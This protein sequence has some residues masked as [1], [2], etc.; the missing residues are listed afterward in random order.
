MSDLTDVQQWK[1]INEQV[2]HVY[3]GRWWDPYASKNYATHGIY[4]M[5][6]NSDSSIG[7]DEKRAILK[8][9]LSVPDNTIQTQLPLTDEDIKKMKNKADTLQQR[10]LYADFFRTYRPFDDPVRTEILRRAWPEPFENMKKTVEET[11]EFQKEFHMS[12]LGG[13]DKKNIM[14][15]L[16]Y[17]KDKDLQDA[18]GMSFGPTTGT[19]TGNPLIPDTVGWSD[20]RHVLFER[21]FLN[22]RRN[23]YMKKVSTFYKKVK[24]DGIISDARNVSGRTLQNDNF[25]SRNKMGIYTP[26]S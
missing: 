1:N 14:L 10:D 21:G 17:E 26:Y 6:F 7:Y 18:I 13:L 23:M 9:G 12:M 5:K 22:P 15:R 2:N 20:D 16:A 25:I 8:N 24:P 19:P 3:G 4:P 11:A